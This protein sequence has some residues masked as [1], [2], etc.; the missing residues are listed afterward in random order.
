MAASLP[1]VANSVGVHA[2]M[3]RHGETGFLADTCE[4]WVDAV[5]RLAHDPELRRRMGAAGRRLLEE[6]YGVAVGAR[7]WLG[8]LDELRRGER[9][10]G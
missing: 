8:L 4:E 3:V 6:R 2:E 5:A 1:V 9:R 7:R 10:A